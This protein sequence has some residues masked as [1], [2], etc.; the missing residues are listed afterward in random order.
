MG[1]VELI[2]CLIP[3]AEAND[4]DA[5]RGALA[6]MMGIADPDPYP[7]ERGR[8]ETLKPLPKVDAE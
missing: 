2:T 8:S 1:L 7:E 3:H 5:A 4:M 6:E